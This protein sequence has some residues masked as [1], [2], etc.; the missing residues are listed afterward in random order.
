MRT[1]SPDVRI[2]QLDWESGKDPDSTQS[3]SK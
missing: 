1:F 2:S 3:R